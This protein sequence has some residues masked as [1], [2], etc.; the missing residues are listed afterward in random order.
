MIYFCSQKNRR[1][2]VLQH[3]TLNGID[4]LEVSDAG[5]DCG[6]RLTVTLLKDGR[7]LS[8]GP[9]QVK[10]SGGSTTSQVTAASVTPPTDAAP[11]VV[12]VDLDQSGDFSPYAF[13]FVADSSTNDPPDGLDPQLSTVT[14][15]FKAGCPTVGDCVPSNCC[16]PGTAPQPDINY[17]A[18]D[19]GGFRQ[20]ILDRMAVLAPGW[21][22][23][24]AS[25]IGIALVEVLAYAADHLSYQQDAVGTEAYLGTARSRISLRRHAKLVDYRI[26]E[27]SNARTW[28]FLKAEKDGVTIPEKTLLF[29]LVP[30]LPVSVS[31][32]G[33]KSAQVACQTGLLPPPAVQLLRN[34]TVGFATMEKIELFKEQNEMPFYTWEDSDCCLASGATEATLAGTFATLSPGAVLIFEELV[35]PQT[36]DPQD[37]DPQHRW[38]VRL[39]AAQT[40]DHLGRPLADPL[41]GKPITRIAWAPEDAPPF[42]VCLSSTTEKQHGSNSLTAVSVA[43]GNIVPADHGIW[44]CW[45]DLG[46]VPA[47]P[48]SPVLAASC[49]CKSGA[50][51]AAP[52]PRYFPQLS[53]SPVTFARS[54][55]GEVTVPAS[56]FLAASPS[57]G[58]P[59]VPQIEVKDDQE[60]RW[61]VVDDLL[62]SNDSESVYVLEIERDGTVFLRFGDGQYGQAP[63]TGANFLARY[64]VG[65][66][67]AGNIG[68]DTL[69]HILT[70]SS[71]V[72][73]V[74]NPLPA[75]GGADPET[76][77]HI[78]QQAPFAFR[79]Q[80]RAV[81]ED[82]YGVMAAQDPAIREARGTLRWTGSWYTAFVS[83]DTQAECGPDAGLL[84]ATTTRMNRLRMAGVDLAVEGAVIVGL[85]IE[86]N[87]CVDPAYFK[88]DVRNALLQLFT[89][90]SLCTGKRGI[91]DP[92]NFTF[93]ETIYASPLV[94]AAQGV[95]GVTAATLTVF[96]RMDDPSIDGVTQGFLTMDRLEIGRCDNDPNRL[97]H[98][99]LIFHMDGGK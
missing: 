68:R 74:R 92:A 17:L 55:L 50:T 18:K 2:L 24:H 35:G 96:E 59:P 54:F 66:G 47:A 44:Q 16:P 37:A 65:N 83:L 33:V 23:T 99:I 78:R 62:S 38:A 98:G 10:I 8:L 71:G 29:P 46:K 88:A 61:H 25:D 91:L 39:T 7:G 43:R 4:Y 87:I 81:T 52:H 48:A 21:N 28:V 60:R 31:P 57:N 30:G 9:A 63:E 58:D 20:A 95:E 41:N 26:S 76:M 94:A 85:R 14:F 79:T 75:V 11:R 80:L 32:G 34:S 36:G 69:A 51:L 6:N 86:M 72:V 40:V 13:S 42:P 93:G 12:T 27:G 1:A 49:E 89:A 15:S 70:S 22:E 82:D 67:S 45:E 77:E 3:P 73:E 5:G 90:G 53:K 97:D 19:Y 64:R 56:Q 84:A